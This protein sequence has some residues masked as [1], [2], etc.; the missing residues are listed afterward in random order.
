MSRERVKDDK[1][2][3][4]AYSEELG[5]KI[6]DAIRAG[7]YM[8][9]AAAFAGVSKQTLYDWLRRGG[10]EEEPF[11]TFSGRVER[12]LGEAEVR[13]VTTVMK[14]ANNGAWQAAAWYLERKSWQNWGRKDKLIA[15]VDSKHT[16]RQEAAFE[17]YVTSDP[18]T[19][20]L[21][22]QLLE[23]EQR[24]AHHGTDVEAEIRT[25]GEE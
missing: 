1:G 11:A 4:S 7:N 16:Q 10:R 19:R 24:M 13:A 23:R 3:P 25:G 22:R 20:D 6:C 5:L 8:E 12:A 18:E 14:A 21:M 2:R 17:H 15:E 9:T